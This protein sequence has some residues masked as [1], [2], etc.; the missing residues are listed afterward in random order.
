MSEAH[1]DL[2]TEFYRRRIAEL[3]AALCEAQTVEEMNKIQRELDPYL[4]EIGN[5]DK[6]AEDKNAKTA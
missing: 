3:Q 2:F 6:A 5:E 1:C 4:K